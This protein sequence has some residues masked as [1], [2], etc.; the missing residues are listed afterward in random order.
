MRQNLVR[1]S[2]PLPFPHLV[3]LLPSQPQGKHLVFI[4]DG[5]ATGQTPRPPPPKDYLGLA[6]LGLLC[7]CFP[8]GI[9]ALFRSVEVIM[10]HSK[11][12]LHLYAYRDIIVQLISCRSGCIEIF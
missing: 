3:F 4:G 6:L 10:D 7:C 2:S 12:Q 1:E 11:L 8:L 9:M 5:G